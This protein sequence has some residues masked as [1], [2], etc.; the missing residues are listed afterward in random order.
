[1]KKVA[2]INQYPLIP[3]SGAR[4]NIYHNMADIFTRLGMHVE[5]FSLSKRN[6]V[7][8]FFGYK[9][10]ELKAYTPQQSGFSLPRLIDFLCLGL[11][12]FRPGIEIMNKSNKLIAAL[13]AYNPDVIIIADEMLAKMMRRYREKKKPTTKIISGN[14][15]AF[16]ISAT[17]GAIDNIATSKFRA[18][19]IKYIKK[20]LEN[21]YFKYQSSL[22]QI[23]ID[24]SD[25][26]IT[27]ADV[28]QREVLRKFPDARGK[29]FTISP[30]YI[31]KKIYKKNRYL[32]QIRNIL[33]LGSCTHGP[34]AIAVNHITKEIAPK[35][36]DKKFFIH[37]KGWPEKVSGNVY[38]SGRSVPFKKIFANIDLCLSPLTTDS[39]AIKTKIFDYLVADK[40]IIGTKSSF[41]GYNITNRFN[42]IIED[43]IRNYYKRIRELEAN[44]SLMRTLQKNI[45]KGLEGHYEEDVLNGWINVLKYAKVI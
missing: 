2:L 3:S 6:G 5:L 4:E 16:S 32:N 19:T 17:F 29:I 38:F 13:N 34:N 36:Q 10:N 42:A 26:F 8:K 44:T 41:I 9:Q 24:V 33:F 39:I 37:G 1:M 27:N 14:S 18:F 31:K 28:A 23:Q 45:P 43:D 20:F 7:S 15:D 30:F 21:K 40:I 35:L 12:G 22:Y 25:I 11:F